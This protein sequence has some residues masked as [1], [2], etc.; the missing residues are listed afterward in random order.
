MALQNP[1]KANWSSRAESRRFRPT[2]SG[3]SAL[4]SIVANGYQIVPT[5]RP[6]PRFIPY[7]GLSVRLGAR[8]ATLYPSEAIHGFFFASSRL[9]CSPPVVESCLKGLVLRGKA[10]VNPAVAEAVVDPGRRGPPRPKGGP[11]ARPAAE[12]TA[13]YENTGYSKNRG[14]GT[15]RR[16]P[17]A[18]WALSERTC[19][20]AE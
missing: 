6:P 17:I 12:S 15:N 1:V 8:L 14:P 5:V 7:G 16:L 3:V 13:T 11:P 10:R 2:A 9:C 18:I 20:S 19:L 4:S